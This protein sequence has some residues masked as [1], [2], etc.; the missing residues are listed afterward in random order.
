M[1]VGEGALVNTK[2]AVH[3]DVKIG[4]YSELSPG[5]IVLGGSEVG[6]FSSVGSG[7]IILPNLKIGSNAVIGAGSVI[8]KDVP[9]KAVVVG[10]PGRIIKFI[11]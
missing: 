1:S 6:K 5:V 3:H 11:K 2:A 8:V 4:N 10:V 7:A 9:D